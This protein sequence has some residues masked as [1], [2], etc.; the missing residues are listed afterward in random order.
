MIRKG[1][2]DM[3]RFFVEVPHEGTKEACDRAIQMFLETGSHFMT[4]ADW[5]CEEGE[6]K[7]WIIL[8]IE[9]KESVLQLIPPIFRSSAKIVALR[10]FSIE[11]IQ[12]V[13]TY[14]GV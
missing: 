14:H 3:P 8:D 4:N 11:D 7:A 2:R 5:G 13:Q 10:R 1:E 12:D 9:D 6:H